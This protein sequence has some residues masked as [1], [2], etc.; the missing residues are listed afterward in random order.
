MGVRAVFDVRIFPSDLK[1][2][3]PGED[4]KRSRQDEYEFEVDAFA[5]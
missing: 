2:D 4:N 5:F 3:D 1:R